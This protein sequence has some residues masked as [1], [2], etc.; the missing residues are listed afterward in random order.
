MAITSA[1]HGQTLF[2]NVG[3]WVNQPTGYA[4]QFLRN[5][6][7]FQGGPWIAPDPSYTVQL[8]DVGTVITINV[9]ASNSSGAGLAAQSTSVVIT[10]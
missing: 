1:V 2:G 9:I 3:L 4:Y 6:V 10:S 8:S 7:V 5:G